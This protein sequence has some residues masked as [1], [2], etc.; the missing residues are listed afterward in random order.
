MEKLK[1]MVADSHEVVR[2]G[3]NFIFKCTED[4]EVI[5]EAGNCY[6]VTR[7][8]DEC[9]PD[10]VIMDASLADECAINT[11]RALKEKHP[12]MKVIMLVSPAD[13]NSIFNA[14]TAGADGLLPRQIKSGELTGAVRM[15]VEGKSMLD[16]SITT[17][18]MNRVRTGFFDQERK[19][20]LLNPQERRI[21][22]LITEGKTNKEI[23]QILMLSN[24]TIKN[25]VS[26]IL[27]KLNFSNRAEAAA[28]AVR[29]NLG[30]QRAAN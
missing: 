8:A 22:G 23:A 27:S 14:I 11:C 16:P 25:Y 7:K 24:N 10:V 19:E 12:K 5:A 26:C 6:E 15:V 17:R 21:L 29:H 9:R 3:I 1:I 13:E 2:L 4:I 20:A 18:V 28:Y 30:Q